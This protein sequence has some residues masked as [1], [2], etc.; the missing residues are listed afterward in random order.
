[1]HTISIASHFIYTID[2]MSVWVVFLGPPT[3][4]DALH[5]VVRVV[6]DRQLGKGKVSLC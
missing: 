3:G 2:S 6:G 5:R 4:L 1:M